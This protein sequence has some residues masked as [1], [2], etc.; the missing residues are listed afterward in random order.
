M[1]IPSKDV[2]YE[3]EKDTILQKAAR[4]LYGADAAS[5]KLKEWTEIHS[6]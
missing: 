5:D 1:E 6:Q 4:I 3:A 2:A